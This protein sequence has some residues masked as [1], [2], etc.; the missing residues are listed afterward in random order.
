MDNVVS[1]SPQTPFDIESAKKLYEERRSQSEASESQSNDD[2][3]SDESSE[4]GVIDRII[5]GGRDFFNQLFGNNDE[6]A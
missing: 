1:V 5:D 4:P 3:N 2:S 6:A